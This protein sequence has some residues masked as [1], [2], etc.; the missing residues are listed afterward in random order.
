LLTHSFDDMVSEINRIK[1]HICLHFSR[2]ALRSELLG[3]FL[4]FSLC[5]LSWDYCLLLNKSERI[6]FRREGKHGHPEEKLSCGPALDRFLP[7]VFRSHLCDLPQ[8]SRSHKPPT[9][10]QATLK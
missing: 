4:I 8:I 7:A 6:F 9:P 10:T 3:R 2:R 5:R 1:R